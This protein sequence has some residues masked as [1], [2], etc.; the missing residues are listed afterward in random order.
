MFCQLSNKYKKWI[1]NYNNLVKSFYVSDAVVKLVTTEAKPR[2]WQ[3]IGYASFALSTAP[4]NK[5]NPWGFLEEFVDEFSLI[6]VFL[7]HFVYIH[8]ATFIFIK[9]AKQ[10]SKKL[11]WKTEGFLQNFPWLWSSWSANHFP[12]F[13][14][15]IL[16][17]ESFEAKGKKSITFR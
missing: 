1:N 3:I 8:L 13:S 7:P 15:I 4:M 14:K 9:H 2:H 17:S 12:E 6:I 10:W 11:F 5:S 16:F